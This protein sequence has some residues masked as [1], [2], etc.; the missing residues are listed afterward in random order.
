MIELKFLATLQNYRRQGAAAMSLN[1]G[2]ALADVKNWPVYL[3]A[4]E[5]CVPVYEKYG[6]VEIDLGDLHINT[7]HEDDN[8]WMEVAR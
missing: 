1:E 4:S 5:D 7:G 3:W 6:F 8:E 2:L